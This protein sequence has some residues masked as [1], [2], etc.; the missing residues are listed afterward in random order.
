MQ[1]AS[2]SGASAGSMGAATL[3]PL[4]GSL[5]HEAVPTSQRPVGSGD[6]PAGHLPGRAACR[7]AHTSLGSNLNMR[8]RYPGFAEVS[9]AALC[10]LEA[11]RSDISAALL[12]G[13]PVV[14]QALD[15]YLGYS[16]HVCDMLSGTFAASPRYTAAPR[17]T[18]APAGRRGSRSWGP[19]RVPRV[20]SSL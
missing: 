19:G 17:H 1:T 18:A 16:L 11:W 10:S 14:R 12:G 8:R 5:H 15:A 2:S 13:E 3:T 20:Q 6:S 4:Q 9:G 7:L